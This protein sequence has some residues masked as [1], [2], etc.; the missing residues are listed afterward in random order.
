M[1]NNIK[2]LCNK[3]Q[4]K[5]YTK[6]LNQILK[7]S[8]ISRREIESLL[9]LS[10]T[11]INRK[12]MDQDFTLSEMIVIGS[13]MGKNFVFDY[14]DAIYLDKDYMSLIERNK[15]LTDELSNKSELISKL[16][17]EISDLKRKISE[18][19]K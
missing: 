13:H 5:G 11:T 3:Q 1:R 2:N 9:S 6:H 12:F 7:R 15:F 4:L 8:N 14:V 19:E 10:H 16:S 18:L 17:K